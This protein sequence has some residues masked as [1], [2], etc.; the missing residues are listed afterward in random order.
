[1]FPN[2]IPF[3]S[4][5]GLI[6][7]MVVDEGDPEPGPEEPQSFALPTLMEGAEG[8]ERVARAVLQLGAELGGGA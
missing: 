7:A 6:D 5:A 8:R 2:L 1:M 4:Y 3:Y